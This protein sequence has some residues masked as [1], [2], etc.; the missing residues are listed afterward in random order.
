MGV[1]YKRGVGPVG[2]LQQAMLDALFRRGIDSAGVAYYG[3][4]R[5]GE[6][7][8]RAR[9]RDPEAAAEVVAAVRDHAAALVERDLVGTSLRVRYEPDGVAIAGVADAAEAAAPGVAVD[10]IGSA[11]ELVKAVG[12][13]DDLERETRTRGF[14]GSHAIGHTR[15]ATESRVDVHHAHPF[16][17][18]PHADIAVVHNGHITNYHQLRRR[19]E[20]RGHVFAT[21]NDSEVIAVYIADAL[22]HGATLEDALT[23]STGDLDG[24][25]AYL[26][27]TADGMGIARDQFATKPVVWAEDDDVVV[28]ASEEIAIRAALPGAELDPRELQ[29]KEVR[30]WLR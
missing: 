21:H 28:L 17:A 7:V 27:S 16:W 8:L 24:T 10:S 4:P 3:E 15:M 13:A 19:Y 25:F 14:V 20:Q 26:V 30:W 18:R 22:E 1:L 5:Q 23:A 6:L 2:E 12:H 9:L 11:L 29:A